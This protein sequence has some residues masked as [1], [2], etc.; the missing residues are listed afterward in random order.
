MYEDVFAEKREGIGL[1]S[2][3]TAGTGTPFLSH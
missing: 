3:L 1:L 2:Y